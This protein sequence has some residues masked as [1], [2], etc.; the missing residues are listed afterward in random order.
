[1]HV[2]GL[3]A[4]FVSESLPSILISHFKAHLLIAHTGLGGEIIQVIPHFDG[5]TTL[6]AMCDK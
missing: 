5:T 3:V 1:M 4:V 6:C 2:E